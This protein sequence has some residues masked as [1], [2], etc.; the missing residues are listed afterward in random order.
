VNGYWSELFTHITRAHGADSVVVQEPW[1]RPIDPDNVRRGLDRAR[2]QNVKALFV[3]HVET[4][5]GAANPV[6]ELGKVAQERGL[7]FV[8]DA[9]QTLGGTEVCTDDWGVDFCI[10]GNHKCMSSPAGLA[11]VAIS[12]RGWQALERRKSPIQ[13]WYSNLL[14]WRDVWLKRQSGYFTFPTS[15]VFGLRAALDLM[16]AMTLSVLYRR[17]AVVAKAIRCAVQE[18]GLELVV[19]GHDCPGCD[20]PGRFCA[21]TVTAIRHPLHIRHEDFAQLM[22]NQYGISIAGTY[23]P[24]AGKA[25]RV[26]PTGLMQISP[27]FT[28]NLLSCIGMTLQQLGFP[29]NVERGLTV[30]NAI[31]TDR[32]EP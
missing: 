10:S 31:L 27:R 7:L 8:V 17:Y 3:T 4:S 6:R 15:L 23:G 22:H 24:L 20:S 5:T 19:S 32:E 26:G 9:A 18:M 13:G 2:S 11:Y 14:V 29:A 28:L 21:D 12:E 30:A 1:G 25:F 16:F